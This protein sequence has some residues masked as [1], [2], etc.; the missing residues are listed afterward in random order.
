[1]VDEK[2]REALSVV[3]ITYNE[4]EDMARCLDSVSWAN[5]IVIVDSG[6]DDRTIEI[7]REYTDRVFERI[8]TDFS[9]Q[10]EFAAS[11]CSNDWVLSIDADEAVSEELQSEIKAAISGG[12]CDAY[13]L[14]TA[15]HMFGG[16]LKHGSGNP[17]YHIRLYRRSKG[18]W[19]GVVHE[20][21]VTGGSVG[22][23]DHPILHYS[24][25]DISSFVASA[26]RY[27]KLEAELTETRP[28]HLVR[29]LYLRPV[30]VFADSFVIQGGYLDGPRGLI[31][32]ALDATHEFLR[33]AKLWV[34]FVPQGV[35]VG[36]SYYGVNT[37]T[38]LMRW[39]MK[40]GLIF[41]HPGAA[42]GGE[43]KEKA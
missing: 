33:W 18:K 23:L 17:D 41:R 42:P 26:N 4:E 15:T 36:S 13:Y 30:R 43:K 34:K 3:V 24:Y 7:V 1:M 32:S 20:R 31:V 25:Q 39:L 5:E 21:V 14:P 29:N 40:K 8:F 9:E 11:K 10:R 2:S 38:R 22:F 35:E 12:R 27:T 6:S 28:G 16:W 19:Y 37:R